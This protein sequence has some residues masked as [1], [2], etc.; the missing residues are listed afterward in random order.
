[1]SVGF[2]PLRGCLYVKFHLGMKLVPGWK[3]SCL[4][5]NFSTVYMFLPRLNILPEWTLPVKKDRDEI[6]CRGEKKKK[7]TSKHFVPGWN[8]TKNMFLLNFLRMYSMCF[9]TLTCLN[10]MK[11]RKIYY[12]AFLLKAKPW[13]WLSFIFFV[14]FTKDWNFS[15]FL[16]LSLLYVSIFN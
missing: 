12:K 5:W 3:H 8:L 4:Q 7:N 14:K 13:E 2:E 15:L 10:L 6:S 11:D 9:P 16:L 1:M